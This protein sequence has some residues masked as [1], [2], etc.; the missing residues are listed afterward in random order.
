MKSKKNLI[1]LKGGFV[2]KRGR[3]VSVYE[4]SLMLWALEGLRFMMVMGIRR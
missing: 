4:K 1:Y 2:K 3:F